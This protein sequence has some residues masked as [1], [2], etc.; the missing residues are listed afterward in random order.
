MKY[1]SLP[2]FTL[3]LIESSPQSLLLPP[4]PHFVKAC[5]FVDEVDLGDGSAPPIVAVFGD[6]HVKVQILTSIQFA[7][8]RETTRFGL[9]ISTIPNGNKRNPGIYTRLTVP[10]AM[11]DN[12]TLPRLFADA[13]PNE[14]V[15]TLEIASDLRPE[16]LVKFGAGKPSKDAIHIIRKHVIRVANEREASGTFPTAFTKE[17]Y[18][19]NFEALLEAMLEEANEFYG[20]GAA[21]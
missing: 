18:L 12:A 20:R 5:A 4:L 19:S 6:K 7:V 3:E 15:S 21:S 2:L 9:S 14:A 16:N 17:E 1:D 8:L 13:G 10:G 11:K